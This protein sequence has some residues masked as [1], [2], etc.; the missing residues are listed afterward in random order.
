MHSILIIGCGSI[1]ERHLRCFQKTGRCEVSVCD[2]NATLLAD[3]AARYAVRSFASLREALDAQKFDALVICTPAH[4][5][6]AIAR[7]GAAHGAALLIEKPLSV[8]L[9][10]IEETRAAITQSGRFAAVAYVYHCFPWVAAA[11]EFLQAGTL[12]HPLHA[13][14][15]AGQHF[16][17]FRPAYRE[18]Y[19][20]RHET[21]GGAIQDALTHLV[22]AME[23]MI[24]PMTRVFCDAAHQHLEGVTVEDTVNV[25]ARHGQAMVSY[26]MTQFQASN[27]A[28]LQIHCENGSVKIESHLQRWGHINRGDKDWTWHTTPPLERDDL[29][30]AQANAFL[31]G[32]ES[33]ACPLSTFDEAVQ[34]LRFNRAALQSAATGLPIDLP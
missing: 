26:A 32:M 33:N 2:A 16:P 30:I 7:E 8:T 27:E 21:G 34:T 31:D 29:F 23:W 22:N 25:T 18:I 1:G 4:T 13:S 19:Y 10:G 12:G 11:R 3:V 9:D 28:V 5:H 20:T 17:T 6:L 24:G 14:V 15:V